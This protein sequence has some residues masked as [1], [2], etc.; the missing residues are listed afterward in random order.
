[1]KSNRWVEGGIKEERKGG[2][3]GERQKGRTKRKEK[4]E[5]PTFSSLGIKKNGRKQKLEVHWT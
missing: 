3:E 5:S 1:M 2:R 4:I